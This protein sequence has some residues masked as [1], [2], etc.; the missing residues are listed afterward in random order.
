[1]AEQTTQSFSQRLQELG[2][3]STPTVQP[4]AESLGANPDQ[5]KMIGTQAQKTATIAQRLESLGQPQLPPS[6]AAQRLELSRIARLEAPREELTV[7]E[8]MEKERA[9][10]LAKLGNLGQ[11]I[12][13]RIQQDLQ[14]AAQAETGQ[15]S[16][17]APLLA[18]AMNITGPELELAKQDPNSQYSQVSAVLQQYAATQDP[19]DLETAFATIDN[20]KAF[21]LSSQDAK[22]LVGLTQDTMAR[23]TGQVV[24]SNVLDQITLG[25]VDLVE[26][27]F[28]RGQQQVAELLGLPEEELSAMTVSEFA[29][30]IEGKQ[31]AEF[32]RV[33]K[34]KAELAAAPLGSV[35]RE[36]LL[37]EL[38]DLGQ[39]GITGVESEFTETVEDID[40]AGYVQVGDEQMKIADFLDD[41]NL[42]QL[43]IDWINETDP[44]KREQ[45]IDTD[46][47]PE[48]VS[49]IEA[50]QMALAKLSGTFDDT[51]EQYQQANDLYKNLN[52]FDDLDLSLNTDVMK[53]I[54]PDWDPSRAVTSSQA[55][56]IQA[57][58][59]ATSIGSITEDGELNR[60]DKREILSKFNALPEE[61]VQQ[62]SKLP[63][64]E[65]KIAHFAAQELQASPDLA[66]FLDID[67][68]QSFVLDQNVQ[69]KINEYADVVS[70]IS[71]ENP[72]W[73]SNADIKQLS[74]E[75][76]K[77]L[78]DNPARYED[79]KYIK[80]KSKELALADTAQEQLNALLG[81]QV[82]LDQLNAEYLE[83][84][85]FASLGDKSAADKVAK[86]ASIFGHPTILVRRPG[87]VTQKPITVEDINKAA[88]GFMEA[89][90]RPNSDIINGNVTKDLL[91]TRETTFQN[92]GATKV[93]PMLQ[94]Y[95]RY[96]SDGTLT[97]QDI[98]GLDSA[99]LNELGNYVDS[100]PYI[101]VDIDGF[102]SF[103]DYKSHVNTMKNLEIGDNLVSRYGFSDLDSFT[104][105]MQELEKTEYFASQDTIDKLS[106]FQPALGVAID[107]AIAAGNRDLAEI[108]TDMKEDVDRA[109]NQIE[110]NRI[111]EQESG[112]RGQVSTGSQWKSPAAIGSDIASA[113]KSLF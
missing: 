113:I 19:N 94:T 77:T 85:K 55:Q 74:A 46:K 8:Q 45:L 83:A 62:L 68:N 50:N 66:R 47:F 49:W 72:T 40:L 5:T 35:K 103:K 54:L 79:F 26:L 90:N 33:Q 4:L 71:R 11:S 112:Y 24:A 110:I 96:V 38:R 88:S 3:E 10:K 36:I 59:R 86:I 89:L 73:L 28:D 9:E 2:M 82:N 81:T 53:A 104:N 41:E 80:D 20:L 51:S 1:M 25:D 16:V 30:A 21:G 42:S 101:K 70:E 109:L 105:M 23:Q 65:I 43:V 52:S 44:V 63:P 15:V 100:N 57:K 91:N 29:D 69:E 108:Y 99:A 58:L 92:R 98:Q 78:S 27:G 67:P 60:N 87:V 32:A 64:S 17:Q 37:R 56:D 12:Q 61:S 76:L 95:E 31:K 84:Q 93:D 7:A 13:N 106:K 97:A 22:R 48:L 75:Q 18:Q 107:S 102:T 39:V 111:P 14:K 6:Q 34:L